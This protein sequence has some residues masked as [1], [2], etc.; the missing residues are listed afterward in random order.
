MGDDTIDCNVTTRVA[1]YKPHDNI[2]LQ[3]TDEDT[4]GSFRSK[5]SGHWTFAQLIYD[6]LRCMTK[7]KGARR[8]GA[9]F[10]Q[11]GMDERMNDD[12]DDSLSKA[13]ILK[14]VNR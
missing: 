9:P 10:V 3:C 11:H 2:R 1:M 6:T 4:L 13:S 12:V 7:H 8:Q 14:P 5:K